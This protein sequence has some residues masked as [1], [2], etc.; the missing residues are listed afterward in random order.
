MLPFTEIYVNP[1][2]SYSKSFILKNKSKATIYKASKENIFHNIP[3]KDSLSIHNSPN[4]Y[5]NQIPFTR[6]RK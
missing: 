3:K 4:S 1:Y 5:S 6:T 2:K